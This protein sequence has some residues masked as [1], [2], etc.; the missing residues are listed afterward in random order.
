MLRQDAF[1]GLF[2]NNKPHG[3]GIAR[4][5]DG[6]SYVGEFDDGKRHG[7]G[8]LEDEKGVRYVGT[9]VLDKRDGRFEVSLVEIQVC[10]T[11]VLLRKASSSSRVV[12]VYFRKNTTAAVS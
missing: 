5:C 9:W 6:S 11:Q 4:Y 3:E 8:T 10:A 2:Q 7:K 1:Y 12:C